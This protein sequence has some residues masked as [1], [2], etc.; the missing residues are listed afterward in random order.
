MAGLKI[1][2]AGVLMGLFCIYAALWFGALPVPGKLGALAI[3]A[4]LVPVAV[5]IYFAL[6]ALFRFEELEALKTLLKRFIGRRNTD[7][8]Q[9]STKE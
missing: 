6:L 7:C 2:S 1:L 4:V 8:R 9:R 5:V 3:V